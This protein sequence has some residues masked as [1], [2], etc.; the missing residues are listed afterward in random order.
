MI[1]PPLTLEQLQDKIQ[2]NKRFKRLIESFQSNR[3]YQIPLDKMKDEIMTLHQT[4]E[5]RTLYKFRNDNTTS[6]VDGMIMANL[7]DQ[8][9]RSRLAE[10][11]L[12]CVR[13]S[14]ALTD[15][16]KLFKDYAIVHY[17]VQLRGIKTKGE[18]SDFIDTVLSDMYAYISDCDL[19]IN[20]T[21]IVIKDIDNAGWALSRLQE[22]L[23]LTISPERKI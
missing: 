22:A 8:S 23:K 1:A 18:R 2:R 9:H 20:L 17:S 16:I 14:S 21:A 11:H 19:V 5:V 7:Q 13:A 15:S 4:R 6:M 10:I 12:Q 3:L